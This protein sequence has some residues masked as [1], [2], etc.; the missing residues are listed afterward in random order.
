MIY[1][2]WISPCISGQDNG[3]Q[4][5][6]VSPGL[7]LCL[8]S[9]PLPWGAGRMRIKGSLPT[10]AQ[11]WGQAVPSQSLRWPR[12]DNVPV[13]SPL[14]DHVSV[15]GLGDSFYEYLIKSWLMSAKTD[16]EAKDM[17]YEALEV[18]R[19]PDS[20]RA[21]GHVP[22]APAWVPESWGLL[23]TPPT[24]SPTPR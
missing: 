23:P 11:A 15:G 4:A 9:A 1:S 21:V 14:A 16:M 5:A 3:A 17:Y 6:L 10:Q 19:G 18:R 8:P 24:L 22:P 13:L 12:K 2:S 7:R 20:L